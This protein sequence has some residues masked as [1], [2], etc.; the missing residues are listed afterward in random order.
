MHTSPESA[1][2]GQTVLLTGAGS[3]IGRAA[4]HLLAADGAH[5]VLVGRRAPLLE[6][7]AAEITAAGG[8]ADGAGCGRRPTPGRQTGRSSSRR[9]RAGGRANQQR[10]QRV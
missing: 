4:A 8:R 3:G 9:G 10:G 6:A 5:L 1:L 2:K 7:V